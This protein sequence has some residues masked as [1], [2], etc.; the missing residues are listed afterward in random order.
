MSPG[1]DFQ[2]AFLLLYSDAVMLILGLSLAIGIL[3]SII[4]ALIAA[5]LGPQAEEPQRME[6]ERE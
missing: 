2:E 5:P 3:L 6:I 4:G 1:L